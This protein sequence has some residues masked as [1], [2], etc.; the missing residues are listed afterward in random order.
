MLRC[1]KNR[2]PN[3]LICKP[4]QWPEQRHETNPT[5]EVVNHN[6]PTKQHRLDTDSSKAVCQE[7]PK[8]RHVRKLWMDWEHIVWLP[9]VRCCRRSAEA[10]VLP[11]KQLVSSK[12]CGARLILNDHCGVSHNI[13]PAAF[14][15]WRFTIYW[16][17]SSGRSFQSN[18]LSSRDALTLN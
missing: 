15:V 1:I 12:H 14:V 9:W 7:R 3:T 6:S 13:R 17:E 4:P 18:K 2:R 5:K 16:M 8:K 10:A 11:L